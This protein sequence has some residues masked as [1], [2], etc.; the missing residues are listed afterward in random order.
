MV[1]PH[2]HRA[3]LVERAIQTFKN[4]FKAEL[5]T[6]YSEFLNTEWDQLLSEGFLTINL[7]CFSIINPKLSAYT[8][9]FGQIDCNR[10]ALS[11]PDSKVVIHTKPSNRVSLDLN[12]K[13]EYY[14]G[15]I[16]NHYRCITCYLPST[17]IEIISNTLVF[18]PHTIPIPTIATTNFLS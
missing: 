9:L 13:I 17:N 1:P 7:I 8:Y 16:S 6:Q 12:D 10:T 2:N 11:P 15:P 4:H 5:S 3:N 18:I 14:T